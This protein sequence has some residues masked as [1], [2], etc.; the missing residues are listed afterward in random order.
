MFHYIRCCIALT[1]LLR[2]NQTPGNGLPGSV[3]GLRGSV[4]P[5]WFRPKRQLQ[6][7]HLSPVNHPACQDLLMRLS[8]VSSCCRSG[9]SSQEAIPPICCDLPSSLPVRGSRPV[10]SLRWSGSAWLLGNRAETSSAGH[11]ACLSVVCSLRVCVCVCVYV[12]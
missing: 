4:L 2:R 12:C 10:R 9:A 6:N 1:G 11:W 7:P 3:L 5:G 8:T